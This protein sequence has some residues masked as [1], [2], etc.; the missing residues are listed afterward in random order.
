MLFKKMGTSFPVWTPKASAPPCVGCFFVIAGLRMPLH[1]A[2]I[3]YQCLLY[4]KGVMK[5][6]R[7]L[8][9]GFAG[10]LAGCMLCF[11]REAAQAAAEACRLW[12]AAV[13]PS[14]F[15]FL[16][17]MLLITGS[18]RATGKGGVSRL[19]GLPALF[20]PFLLLGLLSGS[21]GGS[22]LSQELSI[23]GPAGRAALKRFALYAGTMSPMF[24]VGTLGGWLYS[25][26]LGWIILCAHWL[27]AFFT[28][29]LSR[30]FFKCPPLPEDVPTKPSATPGLSQVMQAA[31]MA[32]FT[33]CGLMVLGNVA[34]RMAQCA[35]P[36]LPEGVLAGVQAFLE[37]TAGCSRILSV[38][39]PGSFPALRPALLCA[40]ASFSGLSILLQN[41][42]FLQEG[43]VSFAFLLKGRLCHALLSF[44][45]CLLLSPLAGMAGVSP[46]FAPAAESIPA[47][48]VAC[49]ALWF[50]SL[51]L[52]GRARNKKL[53]S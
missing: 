48:P 46:A 17:C 53:F 29:Q 38:S 34:A 23:T 4:R 20:Y 43:G 37:V 1:P 51:L 26:A 6:K 8:V 50:L 35:L 15:P 16:V 13:L 14:L 40:A 7:F 22:R 49:L 11:P 36:N 45:L 19:M 18:L 5:M 42:A 39:L 47:L 41:L 12:A 3:L 44:G 25:P 21:P 28:G 2:H 30:L 10:L 52:Q 31:A 9:P 32:M 24:F 33:V 27:G